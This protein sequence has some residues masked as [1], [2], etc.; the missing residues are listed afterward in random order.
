M[1]KQVLTKTFSFSKWFLLFVLALGITVTGCK[2]DYDDDIDRLNG[3]FTEALEKIKT[4]ESGLA[5]AKTAA[6][7]AKAKAE[8]AVKGASDAAEA[9]AAAQ[10]L[11]QEAW[12]KADKVGDAEALKIANEALQLAKDNA[13]AIQAIE[14]ADKAMQTAIN[15]L[16]TQLNDQAARL[17]ALEQNGISQADFDKIVEEV[18]K[19]LSTVIE[20]KIGELIGH[21]L[22]SLVRIPNMTLNDEPA[23]IFQNITYVPQVFDP[24]HIE[25]THSVVDPLTGKGTI[26]EPWVATGA[27]EVTKDITGAKRLYLANE[28]TVVKYQVSPK[29]GVRATD[30][31]EPYF[32]GD[33]Q[34]NIEMRSV[35]DQY[36]GRDYP[37]KVA[38]WSLDSS[39]GVLSVNVTKSVPADVNIN[40]E[41]RGTDTQKYYIASLRV[42]IAEA[43]RTQDEKDN[44]VVPEVASEYSRIAETTVE[45]MIK[46]VGAEAHQD[47]LINFNRQELLNGKNL[48]GQ[49]VHYH[50]SL[51]L[52]QSANTDLVDHK[53]HWN[54]DVD[55]TKY[56][57]V[58]EFEK[59]MID[60]NGNVTLRQVGSHEDMDWKSYGLEFRFALATGKYYQGVN[61]T[62]QQEFAQISKSNIMTSR[63]Y[64]IPG[65]TETAVG[66]EPIVRVQLIDTRNNNNL[67]AQRYIKFRW[68]NEVP[69]T[70]IKVT[71]PQDTVTC[72]MHDN[73]VFTKQMN[74]DFYRQLSSYGLSKEQFH[75]RFKEVQILSLTKDGV[76]ILNV[77]PSWIAP[78]LLTKKELDDTS[79]GFTYPTGVTVTD[80]ERYAKIYNPGG[81]NNDEQNAEDVI[82]AMARD[83]SQSNVSYNLKWFM[84]QHAVGP[85]DRTTGKS[86]YV[87]VVKFIDQ[88]G[89]SDLEVTLDQTIILPPQQ[90]VYQDTYWDEKAQ[91]SG[92]N[93]N[94]NSIFIVNPI[95]YDTPTH[96]RAP[97][98]LDNSHIDTDLV[99][100]YVYG[101]TRRKPTSLAQFI[102]YIRS[103]A[104][105]RFV[106]DEDRLG[107]GDY[108]FLAGYAVSPDGTELWR[109]AVGTDYGTDV[110]GY[111]Q[112]KQPEDFAASIN[113]KFG[114]TALANQD[115]LPWN[116]N[117]ILGTGNDVAN[118]IIRLHEST[119]VTSTFNGESELGTEAALELIGKK[120]PV[121]LVVEYNMYNVIP[122]QKFGVFFIDPLTINASITD[123]FTD[124]VINGSY[125]EVKEGLQYTDW[126]GYKVANKPS[127]VTQPNQTD[128]F[129]ADLWEYY[130][131]DRVVYDVNN[132]KT[133]LKLNGNNLTP[134][135]GYMDG[136]LPTVI[137]VKQVN[138]APGNTTGDPSNGYV[139]VGSNPEYLG[140][141]NANGTPVNLNYKMYV[142][143]TVTYKWGIMKLSDPS[144]PGVEINVNPFT[145]PIP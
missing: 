15:N 63:T 140:Y 67:V 69:A 70:P 17:T 23:I 3:N 141:F 35:S 19:Q 87:M 29:I 31:G 51:S 6:A 92:A 58:C 112:Y 13:T 32:M 139:V 142:P 21:R 96:D 59:L 109:T 82:F 74:E 62:D 120:V 118:A 7:D 18:L 16:Q 73:Q 72:K 104:D 106:F 127:D 54:E 50:D 75:G 40:F 43:N 130:A 135:A 88:T 33:I 86:N 111:F 37:I 27:G 61:N 133:N 81:N 102:Q 134:T 83:Q 145:T 34:T 22:T 121:N 144:K 116:H 132:I 113:N 136:P 122:V 46:Q 28:G 138:I 26:T 123:E 20:P 115:Y 66:R 4:L 60:A 93:M 1:N 68:T 56:V 114:A 71:F 65:K 12:D 101:P 137:S 9:A 105:V 30:I 117:E 95:M 97:G 45:P 42:P 10:K 125:V 143:V 24:L 99:N 36:T 85:I 11:A 55:L 47:H 44:S 79:T 129:T 25:Y 77:A 110:N 91:P 57:T 5:D 100:G 52:Y 89:V 131:V 38:S 94:D 53:I 98:L 108:A 48:A 103:C 49:Y 14:L 76:E 126:R 78:T 8:Q 90:F 80:A 128:R 107:K 84:S 64:T 124:A 41:G 119:S 39:T 2:E